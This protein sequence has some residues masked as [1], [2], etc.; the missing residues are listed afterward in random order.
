MRVLV[1]TLRVDLGKVMNNCIEC[2]EKSV[3][4][5]DEVVKAFKN[6]KIPDEPVL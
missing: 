6:L 3:Y 5:K 2:E 4:N 1:N